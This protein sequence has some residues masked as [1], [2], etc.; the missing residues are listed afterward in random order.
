M[1]FLN[2]PVDKEIGDKIKEK[3]AE[4]KQQENITKIREL[5]PKTFFKNDFTVFKNNFTKTLDLAVEKS[6]NEHIE[7]NWKNT[8]ASRDFISTGLEL[9]SIT[10][11]CV[12]CGQDLKSVN[13]LILDYKKVFSNEYK[14]LKDLIKNKGDKFVSLDIEKELLTF[15]DCGIDLESEINKEKL[16]KSKNNIDVKIESKQQD[17]NLTIDF[18]TDVDFVDFESELSKIKSFLKVYEQKN[19]SEKD[20][21]TLKKELKRLEVINGRYSDKTLKLCKDFKD[22]GEEIDKIKENISK[23]NNELAKKVNEVFKANKENINIYL[24]QMGA[25]FKLDKFEPKI[26]MGL[27]NPHFCDYNFIFNES[28]KVSLT[29]KKTQTSIEPE[30]LPHF[31]NT[32]SDSDKRLLGFSFFLSKLKNDNDLDQKII[33]FDDPFSSFDENRKEKTVTLLKDIE[34]R[35]AKKPLQKIILTHE[36]GF[37]CLC[38]EKLK[39]EN[40]IK[41]LKITY[42]QK[43]GSKLSISNI[44]DEFIKEDYFK[45]IE[46]IKSSADNSKNIDNA[47]KEVRPCIEH[48]LKRKYYFCLDQETLNTKSITSYLEKIGNECLVKK[49][50]LD[51]NW[52]QDMHDKHPIMRL[53]EPE[54]IKKLTEFLDLIKK[55]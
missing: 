52:H 32:L 23:K 28:Q 12:F 19:A 27:K 6:I 9:L 49:N 33:I 8:K 35:N 30:D 34:N 18:N 31:K 55:I 41:V 46:Y 44:E 13:N 25:D 16:I 42:S 4:I 43:E 48:L 50:I 53:S 2:I 38:Y 20:I 24:N 10:N 29:N 40:D 11:N 21:T 26:H 51:S 39:T 3:E 47:L 54:K 17:L 37:L 45:K 1:I 15:K 7:K 36:I 14:E 5:L 22:K